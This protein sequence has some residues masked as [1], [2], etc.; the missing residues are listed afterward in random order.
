VKHLHYIAAIVALLVFVTPAQV[1]KRI[2][3]VIGNGAY[4]GGL[5]PLRS[6]VKDAALMRDFGGAFGIRLAGPGALT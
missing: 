5:S 1:E 4:K 6:P 2:A 3:L